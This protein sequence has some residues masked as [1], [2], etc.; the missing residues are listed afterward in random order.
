MLAVAAHLY[1]VMPLMHVNNSSNTG[2]QD[3][4]VNDSA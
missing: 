3:R 4:K 2:F 1:G